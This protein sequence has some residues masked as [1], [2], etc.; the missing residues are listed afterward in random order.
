MDKLMSDVAF[1]YMQYGVIGLI[2][3]GGS[4][5]LIWWITKGR[6]PGQELQQQ[7]VE[8]M[9]KNVSFIDRCTDVIDRLGNIIEDNTE[10]RRE[11]VKC[12]DR[13]D[14]RMTRQGSQLDDI[15]KKQLLCL[16]RQG[17]RDKFSV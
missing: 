4:I 10:E 15:Q 5:L 17:R 7:M 16:D 2:I 8:V 12:M 1:L 9:A 6:K 11:L 13:L 14:E 3:I